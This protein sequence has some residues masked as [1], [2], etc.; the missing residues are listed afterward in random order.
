MNY[1]IIGNGVAGITAALTLR[2]RDNQA[3]IT[4]IS[5]ESDYFFSRTGL[6]YAFMD[7]LSTRDL[8]PHE[9]KTYQEQRITRIRARVVNLDANRRQ[10]TLDTSA[11]VAYDALLLATGSVPNALPGIT[12]QGIVNFVTLQDLEACERLTPST[13][14]AV[15]I[16]GGLIGVE[17]VECL[18]HHGV[19]VTFLVRENWYW[20]MALAAE[21][22]LM[23]ADHIRHHGVDL[24]LNEELV[25]VETDAGGRVK[26]IRT[27]QGNTLPCQL[28]GVSIGV[29]PQIDWLR[30]V[31]SPPSVQRGVQV[32][33]SFHTSLS[34]VWA[35]GD[36]AE[37]PSGKV[38]QIWYSAKRQGELAA[39]SMLGD[40]V[41]YQPPIFYNSAKFFDIEY[42]TVGDVIRIPDSA[43]TF[44]YRKPGTNASLRVIEDDGRVV[45]FNVLG[46]RWNH[47]FFERWILER[48]PLDYVLKHLR[49]AQFDV[50]FGRVK[51]EALAHG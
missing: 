14:Q 19:H 17:L 26:E 7:K 47:T 16:G 10:L 32:D 8:E 31:A 18:R 25:A 3:T 45:G 11:T 34:N 40:P 43:R 2:A 1:V 13:R 49:Q 46:S 9:R 22:G 12:A 21:E 29:R 36:C 50:E 6:M 5:A 48:R 41:N 37:L 28:L 4:V 30:T 44:H 24:R 23:V 38:E 51:F 39:R 27:S 15:V 33:E 35:A 20:P 42:T